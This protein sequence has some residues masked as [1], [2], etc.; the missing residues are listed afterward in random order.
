MWTTSHIA[1]LAS[2]S[3]AINVSKAKAWLGTLPDFTNF[4]ASSS[5]RSLVN[6]SC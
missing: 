3:A 5:R 2:R 6:S 4:S 1:A